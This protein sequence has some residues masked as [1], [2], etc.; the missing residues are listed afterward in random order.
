M[1]LY[2]RGSTQL[3]IKEGYLSS[4]L[5]G[6]VYY[7]ALED[8]SLGSMGKTGNACR[9]TFVR[10]TPDNL[11]KLVKDQRAIVAYLPCAL[12][13]TQTAEH[14]LK[15]V[16]ASVPDNSAAKQA[17]YLTL[18]SRSWMLTVADTAS[19]ALYAFMLMRRD[20]FLTGLDP[21]VDS[22]WV[23]KMR[24]APFTAPT[25]FGDVATQAVQ[26]LHKSFC[27]KA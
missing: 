14:L 6:P 26:V 20:F 11:K 23:N 9:T 8:T 12:W 15:Q 24:A 4:F 27:A 16:V 7:P 2:L 10:L 18:S 5:Y 25:L 1:V 19:V 3:L 22:D 17:V 13:S 21:L